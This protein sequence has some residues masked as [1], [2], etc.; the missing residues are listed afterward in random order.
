MFFNRKNKNFYFNSYDE[1]SYMD[2]G[3]R[4]STLLKDN[5]CK[6]NGGS[7]GTI[8]ILCIGTDKC[9]G[10]S[11]G[12]LIGHMLRDKISG[13]PYSKNIKI[14]GTLS[15]P[16][17]ARNLEATIEYI[18][19]TFPQPFIIAIDA[20]LGVAEHVGFATVK[21]GS[22]KPGAGV[23]KHLPAVGDV[24]ITGIVNRTSSKN[25]HVLFNSTR[26]STV[27]FLAEYIAS[28]IY[29]SLEN[30][31]EISLAVNHSA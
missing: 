14:C 10:D 19:S 31:S 13:E 24:C 23:K 26:L 22:L 25:E 6:K 1:N 30:F 29:Y 5:L 4:L 11:L 18:Y 16:V 17:H 9:V 28:A 12:P 2:F 8:V 15:E 3:C 7:L 21:N 27:L 20:S